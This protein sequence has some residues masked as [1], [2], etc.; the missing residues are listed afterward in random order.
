MLAAREAE[1][2]VTI[3]LVDDVYDHGPVVAQA[4]VAVEREDTAK[5]LAER[6]QA[7]EQVL[8]PETLQR[9]ITGEINLD[10]L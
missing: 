2:G 8:F 5:I 3:H 6:V 7:R 9:I 4:R 1:T 10:R